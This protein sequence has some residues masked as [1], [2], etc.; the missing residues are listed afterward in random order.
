MKNSE[1]G[2]TLIEMIGVLAIMGVLSVGSVLG[3][4]KMMSQQKI[5]KAIEQVNVMASKISQIG[6]QSG[7]YDGL[8]NKSAS[9]FG[10]V[11]SMAKVTSDGSTLENPFGGSITIASANLSSTNNDQQ[12]Y[13]IV[14]RGVPEEACIAMA[15]HNWGSGRNSALV[16][17]GAGSGSTYEATIKSKLTQ[18]CTG[19]SDLATYAVACSDGTAYDIPMDPGTAAT[20][21]GCSS[22]DCVLVWMYF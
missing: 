18:D 14:Y 8:N 12:A 13:T 22:D 19:S 3:F 1:S 16:G 15:S 17:V 10:A 20:A 5:N 11:P 7:S 4:S 9:K 6:A 21:C 2:R